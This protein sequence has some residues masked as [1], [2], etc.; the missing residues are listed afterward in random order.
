MD[1][2]QQ[3]IEEIKSLYEYHKAEAQKY[4]EIYRLMSG[5]VPSLQAKDAI[6]E[7]NGTVQVKNTLL[8]QPYKKDPRPFE[9]ILLEILSDGVPRT[10]RELLNEYTRLTNR[11]MKL[12]DFTGRLIW[13]RKKGSIKTYIVPDRPN[14]TKYVYGKS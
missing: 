10:S 13:F 7:R 6:S 12:P 1:K 8:G 2:Q 5:T 14:E 11:E 4:Q 9:P 3:L